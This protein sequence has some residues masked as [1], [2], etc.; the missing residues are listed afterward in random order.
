VNCISVI[1]KSITEICIN[2]WAIR[3]LW[4]LQLTN[5]AGIINGLNND[6][7]CFKTEGLALQP[8]DEHFSSVIVI[9]VHVNVSSSRLN[10]M[11]PDLGSVKGDFE[12]L[13]A[14]RFV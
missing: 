7:I 5:S 13:S 8:Y 12:V 4:N 9:V 6:V 14:K 2:W 11:V 10:V 3:T 1:L